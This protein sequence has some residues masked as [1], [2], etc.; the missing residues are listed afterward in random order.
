M[1]KDDVIYRQSAIDVLSIGK[2]ILRRVLDNMDV[3]GTEREKYSWGLELIESSIEDI[4]KLPPAEPY[5]AERR[6]DG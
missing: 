1:Q 6:I 5:K 3:V 2:E 4:E